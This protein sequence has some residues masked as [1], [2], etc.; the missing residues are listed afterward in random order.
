MLNEASHYIIVHGTNIY[1]LPS[2]A[3]LKNNVRGSNESWLSAAPTKHYYP[4]ILQITTSKA[5]KNT[6][7]HDIQKSPSATDPTQ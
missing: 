1:G 6:V 2:A 3:D 5:P 7:G 4:W